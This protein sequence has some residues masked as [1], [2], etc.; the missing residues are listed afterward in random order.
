MALALRPFVNPICQQRRHPVKRST[1]LS[2][3]HPVKGLV[4][5]AAL[6]ALLTWFAAVP[7]A[8]AAPGDTVRGTVIAEESS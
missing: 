6:F 5:I 8:Q 2:L 3:K 4:L 1:P 7:V